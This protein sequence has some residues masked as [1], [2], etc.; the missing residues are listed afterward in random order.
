MR[1]LTLVGLG[2][3]LSLALVAPAQAVTCNGTPLSN[4]CL[5][6]ITGGDT[7]DPDDGFAV[8]NDGGIPFWDFYQTKSV[9]S[10]GWPISQRWTNGPFTLQA[11]QKVI[12]QWSPGP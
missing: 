12:L 6:T 7:A 2:V 9:Q 1:N 10:V 4:G 3:L 8:T 5:F 11:F